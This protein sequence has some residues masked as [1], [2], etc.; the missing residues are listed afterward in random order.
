MTTSTL[1][2]AQAIYRTT[3]RAGDHWMRGIRRGQIFRIVDLEGNQAADTLFYNAENPEDRYAA[4]V[5]I[6]RQAAL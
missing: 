6:R 3:V 2:P 5:T 4:D 1:D